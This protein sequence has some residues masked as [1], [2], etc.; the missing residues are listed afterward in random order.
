M[1]AYEQINGFLVDIWGRINKIEERALAAGLEDDVSITEI[2]II[3]KIGDKPGCRMSE[4]ARAIGVT[5]ATL[6]V[7][8]DKLESKD[9]ITRT[10]DSRDKRVVLVELTPKGVAAYAFHKRFHDR[11]VS[12]ALAG[13]SE[14]ESSALSRALTKLRGF[15]ESMS[16]PV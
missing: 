8:C 14:E 12:A 13:M 16:E 5:L 7:A 11:M 10:R 4:I 3:E 9:L 6:T 2:H 15:F 1:D